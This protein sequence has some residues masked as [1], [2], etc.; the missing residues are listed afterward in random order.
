MDLMFSDFKGNL[1]AM[2]NSEAKCV[3]LG[4]QSFIQDDFYLRNIYIHLDL[5]VE[6]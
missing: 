1:L 2:K 3:I 5:I 6:S 4:I